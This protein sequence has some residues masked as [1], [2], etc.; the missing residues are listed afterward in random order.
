MSSSRGFTLVEVMVALAIGG[1]VVLCAERMFAAAADGGRALEQARE[2]LDRSANARRWLQATFLSLAVGDSGSGPFD[3][4]T[5]R[6][7]FTAWQMTP[8]GWLEP[9]RIELSATD[10]RL[11]ALVSP[12]ELLPLAVGVND[13]AFDYLLEPGAESRWVQQWISPVSAPLAVRIRLGRALGRADTLLVLIK[14]RG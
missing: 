4:N 3:G 10:G 12:G 11:M 8:G 7:R 6:L 2:Q 5:D 1:V 13:L 14:E 9:R